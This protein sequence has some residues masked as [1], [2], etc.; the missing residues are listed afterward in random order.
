MVFFIV[1][2]LPVSVT[3]L[4]DPL[5]L[6][7]RGVV[8]RRADRSLEFALRVAHELLVRCKMEPMAD[9]API[10]DYVEIRIYPARSLTGIVAL[11]DGSCTRWGA[12]S[13][14]LLCGTKSP[15]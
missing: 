14:P 9:G 5:T 4:S 15:S 2:E 13:N 1:A 7:R 6:Q 10:C 11:L 8:R 12:R 3:K